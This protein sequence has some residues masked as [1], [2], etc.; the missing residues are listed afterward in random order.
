MGKNKH[1]VTY[2]DGV[3]GEEVFRTTYTRISI[4][5]ATPAFVSGTPVREGYAFTGWTPDVADTVTKTLHIKQDGNR[6]NP[7]AYASSNT[8]PTP[9]PEPAPTPPASTETVRAAVD[10]LLTQA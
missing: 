4:W 3:D 2:N 8:D 6:I 5:E 7:Y 1:T 9:T 10:K